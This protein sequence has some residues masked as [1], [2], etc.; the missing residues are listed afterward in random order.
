MAATAI[1]VPALPAMAQDDAII[2]DTIEVQAESDDILVQDGFVATSGRIGSK[3]DTPLV[4]VP[5][6]ISTVTE[7]QL[8]EQ[9]PRTLNEALEYT[10]S[11]R[12]GGSGFDPR[13]DAFSIR[14]FSAT[15]NGVFRDGLR[16]FNSPTGLFRQ[17]PYSLEGVTILKGPSSALYGASS[18]GGLVNLMTKRPTEDPF[19]EVEVQYG[20]HDRY[21]GN[22]DI[23]G[24]ASEDGTLLYRLTGLLRQSDTV[25]EGFPDDRAF[26]APAVT[27]QPTEDTKL[28]VLT[29]YMDSTLGGTAAFYNDVNG[30]T[31]LYS[32][33]STYNDF[34]QEQARAGYEFEHSFN[35][36]FT[37][38]QNLRYTW[39][40]MDLEYATWFVPY[41]TQMAGRAAE[42]AETLVVDNQLLSEFYTGDVEHRVL[43]GLDY[44]TVDYEQSQYL[45][46]TGSYYAPIPPEG[47]TLPLSFSQA[48]TLTQTGV[49]A[50]DQINWN[51]LHVTLGGRYDW[52]EGETRTPASFVEQEDEQFS[53]RAGVSYETAIGLVPY[54]NYTTSFTPN[55]GT[56]ISGAPANPTIGEQMEAGVKYLFKDYNAMVTAAVFDI[57][58]EDAVVFEVVNGRNQQV[59]RDLRS[60]GFELEASASLYSGLDMIA[61]YS[62][63]DMEITESLAGYEGN[64][65]NSVPKHT[66]SLWGDYTVQTGGF[67]GLGAALG[68]RY[69]GESYGDDANTVRND[70]HTYVDAAVHY[71]FG[72]LDPE[73]DGLRLQVNAK[74]IFDER[75]ETCTAGYCYKDEG[76]TVIGSLRYRW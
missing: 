69:V 38:R 60:R 21:Q 42:E 40:D 51:G 33:N 57:E 27:W 53:W 52:L 76:R 67:A 32:G 18:A 20:N 66:V 55:V 12:T 29:E 26:I 1:V 48:Q 63:V 56:L 75:Y 74:N 19:R 25:L 8:D 47:Q 4:Q 14:G 16:Q 62:Y 73:L 58:Q 50:S 46:A 45:D 54:A 10:P 30:V 41:V 7:R 64:Q 59:N 36:T 9:N 49:Y 15:Y 44:G 17:E 13:F 3:I 31:D 37:V 43:V 22:F 71:D 61:A 6:S 11:V 28:T 35:E 2:L 72:K 68:V 34:P 23:S 39:V 5:Q 24:P 70:A 65:L